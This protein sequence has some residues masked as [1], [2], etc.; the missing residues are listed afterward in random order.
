MTTVHRHSLTRLTASEQNDNRFGLNIV[1][2]HGLRGHPRGTWEAAATT[3]ATTTSASNGSNNT[4]KKPKGLKSLFKRRTARSLSTSAEQ[5]QP[6][7]GPASSPPPATVF[8]PEEYLAA[9][10]PQACVWTYG[11]NADVI[12]DLFQA[13]NKNSIS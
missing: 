7:S 1:F 4:T 6:P 3:V 8:W 11:Y 5:A 9:D 10:I 2:V 12:G 13:N